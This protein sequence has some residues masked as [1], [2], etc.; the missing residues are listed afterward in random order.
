M[1]KKLMLFL[2]LVASGVSI[3]DTSPNNGQQKDAEYWAKEAEKSVEE[4]K[5]IEKK[6]EG[7]SKDF[8]KSAEQ[9]KN[10]IAT[11]IEAQI[12]Q[13]KKNVLKSIEEET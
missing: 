2:F 5:E 12:E 7:I 9:T 13:T 11:N 1:R 10:S 3:A 4:V 8:Q 6:V